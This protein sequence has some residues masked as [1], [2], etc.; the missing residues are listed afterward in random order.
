MTADRACFVVAGSRPWNR[1]IAEAA[2]A[3]L[4]GRWVFVSEPDEL[5]VAE[6]EALD[7]DAVFFLHWSWIVPAEIVDRWECVVFHMAD[8]PFGRGGSPLQNLIAR[9]HTTTVLA[10]LRMTSEVDAGP[11]Y[12]KRPLSLAGTAE[13]VYVRATELAVRMIADWGADRPDPV[14]QVGEAVVFARRTPDQS[15]LSGGETLDEVHDLIRMV[16]ADGYPRAFVQIGGLRL[17]L[18]RSARYDGRVEADVT[19]SAAPEEDR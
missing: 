18:S 16:D 12:E 1:P 7:P 10:A 5:G 3:D 11:V 8:V 19:I 9:G 6:L 15:R 13:A 4:P 17:E 2:L 14:D